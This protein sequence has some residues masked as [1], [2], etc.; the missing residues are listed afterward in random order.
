MLDCKWSLMKKPDNR[1]QFHSTES[2]SRV[3]LDTDD[4]GIRV[5]EK[6][7]IEHKAL[8]YFSGHWENLLILWQYLI[9]KLQGND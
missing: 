9:F 3:S 4:S 5:L 1:F 8:V 6:S 7:R 2:E